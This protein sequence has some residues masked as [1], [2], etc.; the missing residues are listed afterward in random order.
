LGGVIVLLL[1]VLALA[2]LPA[3]S[4]ILGTAPTSTLWPLRQIHFWL[5]VSVFFLLTWL[6]SVPAEPVYTAWAALIG[7]LFF[8]IMLI[9]AALPTPED[10]ALIWTKFLVKLL[11]LFTL[12]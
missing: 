6:G 8:L 9:I 2:A 4:K 10:Y 5:L 3:M 1:A 11:L 7:S 12:T